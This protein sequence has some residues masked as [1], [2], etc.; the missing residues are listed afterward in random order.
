MDQAG[1]QGILQIPE[2]IFTT[3]PSDKALGYSKSKWVAE[4]I[5]AKASE[6]TRLTGKIKVLRIGQLTGDTENGVWNRS[7]AWPLMLSASRTLGCL[8]KL[9]E[10]LNWLPVDIAARAVVD[11]SLAS[12]S[13]DR[14]SVYHLVNNSTHTTWFNLLDWTLAAKGNKFEV[15]SP[16]EWLDRLEKLDSDPA[17]GL[18][19]L[20]RTNLASPAQLSGEAGGREKIVFD[21]KNAEAES[22]YMRGVGPVDEDLVKKIWRWL[23]ER[24]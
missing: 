7:E 16:E 12:H 17:K 18:L 10:T 23:G 2:Q 6:T 8:P 13:D 9:D 21:T 4:A 1:A 3:P 24:D 20:W 14:C 11:I 19:G 15:V 5:C 22:A